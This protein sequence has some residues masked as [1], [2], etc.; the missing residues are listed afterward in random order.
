M[1]SPLDQKDPCTSALGNL[2]CI[3]HNGRAVF[4]I[5][6]RMSRHCARD[7]VV[8]TNGYSRVFKIRHAS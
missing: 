7:N 5:G 8:A 4:R 2:R 1:F 6:L 3:L